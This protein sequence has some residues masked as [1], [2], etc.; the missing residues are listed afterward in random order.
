[1]DY[2]DTS[3]KEMLEKLYKPDKSFK[4][5][6]DVDAISIINELNSKN[7]YF[8]TSS[9][10]GRISLFYESSTG[11]KQ[12]AG[13]LFVQHGLVTKKELVD[14]LK[15]LPDETLWFKMETPI[16]H[17]ACRTDAAAE[18]LLGICRNLGFKRSGIIATGNSAG[19]RIMIEIIFNDKIEVPVAMNK[20]LF[21]DENFIEFMLQKANDKFLKNNELLKKFEKELKKL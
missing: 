1:M 21:V 5:T 11:K 9:C 6:V 2:F 14:A 10:S 3:K 17:I 8:T 16:F 13:W 12:D 4:G 20:K 19:K 7:D 15:E 18:T